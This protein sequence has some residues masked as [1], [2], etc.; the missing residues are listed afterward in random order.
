MLL[1]APLKWPVHS[2]NAGQKARFLRDLCIAFVTFR[3]NSRRSTWHPQLDDLA[4]DWA[5]EV[6]QSDVHGCEIFAHESGELKTGHGKLP[7][8]IHERSRRKER[9]F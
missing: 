3:V 5:A 1:T 8:D 7:K 4:T 6:C 9:C 2:C